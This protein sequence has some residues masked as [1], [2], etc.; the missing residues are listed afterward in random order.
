MRD[1]NGRMFQEQFAATQRL[2][3]DAVPTHLP[4]LN[5][6]MH[7]DGGQMGFGRGWFVC[8][9]GLTGH[10]KSISALNF[11]VAALEAGEKVAYVSLEMS[12]QQIAARYYAIAGK[13]PII[14]L[15]RGSFNERVWTEAQ[16]GLDLPPLL[17]P[18]KIS[19]RWEDQ[20]SFIREAVEEHG[21]TYVILDYL[22][23]TSVGSEQDIMKAISEVTTD[24]RTYCANNGVV[25][26]VLSQF[27]RTTSAEFRTRPRMT[28]L[29]GGAIIE[30][31]SD[32]VLLLSHHAYERDG[33]CARTYIQVEKNRHGG[34]GD[35]PIFNS[36]RDL[37]QRQGLPDELEEWP[38]P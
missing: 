22:Q 13:V 36:Y 14:G 15:E 17:V 25:G 18:D 33:D 12:A 26:L 23:L 30:Q 10:G 27:N 8:L 6:M 3:P 1:L 11:C 2:D 9:A 19:G 38:K 28:G 32:V 4:A 31:S 5:A 21:A 37:T 29:W 24:L 16:K 7:D 35:I 34:V 20:V